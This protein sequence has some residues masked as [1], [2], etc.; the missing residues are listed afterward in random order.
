MDRDACRS[1]PSTSCPL[2]RGCGLPFAQHCG[3]APATLTF[4]ATNTPTC[5]CE[6]GIRGTI[7]GN[8][9]PNPGPCSPQPHG[10]LLWQHNPTCSVQTY[11][12]GLR[13]C[14]DG[15]SLLDADQP[16]PWPDQYLEYSLKFRFYFEEYVPA[17]PAYVPS[18]QNLVRL[19]WTTEA[20]AGEY[21]VPQCLPGVAAPCFCPRMS[22]ED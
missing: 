5:V 16:V 3:H 2:P 21:D 10:D 12:G 7:G 6:G 17:R 22:Q 8:P 13:C 11:V 4:F 15:K 20:F 1:S 9:F 18:H 14:R 19:Y